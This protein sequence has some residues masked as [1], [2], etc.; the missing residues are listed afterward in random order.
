MKILMLSDVYFPRVNGVSTS[1]HTFRTALQTL[2]HEVTIIAPKYPQASVDEPG[3]ERSRTTKRSFLA[4][5]VWAAKASSTAMT[6]AEVTVPV[7]V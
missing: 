3:T 6:V 4:W 5:A 1:M 2:G 7:T